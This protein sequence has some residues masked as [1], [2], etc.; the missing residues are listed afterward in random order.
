MS[1][2]LDLRALLRR[3]PAARGPALEAHFKA[4]IS[5]KIGSMA[6]HISIT[7]PLSLLGVESVKLISMKQVV[8]ADL[9]IAI[10]LDVF[11]TDPSIADLAEDTANRLLQA[12]R[13]GAEKLRLAMAANFTAEPVAETLSYWMDRFGYDAS[14]EFAPYNQLFQELLDPSGLLGSNQQGVNIILMRV[15]DWLRFIEAGG[16]LD[17]A[18]LDRHLAQYVSEFLAALETAARRGRTPYLVCACPHAPVAPEDA[19]RAELIRAWD[20]EL[21]DGLR[22]IA[23]VHYLDATS[24]GECYQ[25][26]EPF[27]PYQEMLGHIPFTQPL[28]AALGTFLARAV[29]AL[30]RPPYKVVILDCDQ[31]LWEG[32]CGEDG[33]LG[34]RVG[35]P[36]QALQQF[37]LRRQEEGL[38][39]CLCSKNREEDVLAVFRQHPDM[40]LRLEHLADYRINW[41]SKS[42]NL[43]D[44]ARSLNL[45]L[46]A[47]LFVDDNPIECA[48]VRAAHPEV[49]VLQLPAD[50]GDVAVFADHVWAFDRLGVTAEDRK[51][52]ELY[53]QNRRREQLRG[54]SGSLEDFLGRLDLKVVIE[55]LAAGDLERAAQL[56]Q[57]TNQFNLTTVRRGE[58]ELEQLRHSPHHHC[59]GVRVSD[60]FGDYGMVGLLIA[61]LEADVVAVD[62]FLLSC[63]V[64]GRRVEHAMLEALAELALATGRDLIR[65]HYRPTDRN[66]PARSFV[67]RMGGHGVVPQP[68]GF[69]ALIPASAVKQ[70]TDAD[71]RSHVAAVKA[72]PDETEA[73]ADPPAGAAPP[74]DVSLFQTVALEFRT[75]EHVLSALRA[76]RSPRPHHDTPYVAP[77]SALEGQ[78]AE[79]FAEVLRLD[80]VGLH[81]DFFQLGGDS[82]RS[83]QLISAIQ[84]RCEVKLAVGIL[85]KPTVAGVARAVE[86]VRAGRTP[87]VVASLTSLD[88]EVRLAPEV[89][90]EG[91]V[92]AAA[93]EPR[94]ILLTGASGYL[95]AHLLREL[96]RETRARIYCLVR[97]ADSA[98]ARERLRSNLEFHALWDDGA[99]VDRIVPLVGDQS[100]T[101]LGLSQAEFGRLADE[102]DLI[103][104]NGAWVN[105]IYPYSV[106]RAANVQSTE[107]VLR[108]ASTRRVKP[109]HF[110]STI[111]V[112]MSDRYPRGRIITEDDVP[113][114]SEGLPNGYEQTKWVSDRMVRMARERGIPCAVYRPCLLTGDSKGVYR[115]LNEFAACFFKGC[116]QLNCL[117]DI[118]TVVDLVPIDFASQSIV[119]ISLEATSLGK[120]F[121]ISHP[122]APRMREVIDWYRDFGYPVKSLRWEDWKALLAGLGS[123]R[124]EN[125]LYPFSDFIEGMRESQARIPDFDMSNTL[126]VVRRTGLEAPDP[127]LLLERYFRYFIRVGFVA[128]PPRVVRRR[129]AP[130]ALDH[131]AAS[132]GEPAL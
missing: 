68:D 34:V 83:A 102:I 43:A 61:F 95:G 12:E 75:S 112:L 63:R 105:F 48:E 115:K 18:A 39:L 78:L 72:P 92:P 49:A 5:E 15:E 132:C 59:L 131:Q 20:R 42:T 54:D 4:L 127:F 40:I 119:K 66:T 26:R 37:L 106:L 107:E 74:F 9:G 77:R 16:H 17:L 8:E 19:G 122:R 36:F 23:G 67:S 22:A 73:A 11:L 2:R 55:P 128:P 24:L 47:F 65:L 21:A 86:D 46:D 126:D 80:R 97:A 62:T 25:V 113:E 114:F 76:R 117:P 104:H 29:L 94:A 101:R 90:T 110:I 32:V 33:P 85:E 28:F 81:D 118:D 1:T 124:A 111:G 103:Y 120:C 121:H 57:R 3:P 89:R 91:L 96:L 71:L 50:P 130:D 99:G 82:L 6:G 30:R 38:L 13:R 70:R 14:I 53:Q 109:L 87:A 10:P 64:L 45:S 60:R 129:L 52:T 108:L 125:A 56:T 79:I 51:R 7:E 44:L 100:A 31:T 116:V 35:P 88:A 98:A 84:E 58:G 41:E 69:D 27:D 93:G 123:K